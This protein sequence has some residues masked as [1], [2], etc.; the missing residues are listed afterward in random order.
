MA[1]PPSDA[2]DTVPP[3]ETERTGRGDRRLRLGVW[4][5]LVLALLLFLLVGSVPAISYRYNTFS[6]RVTRIDRSR[7]LVDIWN[8]QVSALPG[9]SIGWLPGFVFVACIVI[10]V[11]CAVAG[12]WLL[13][14]QPTG[15][16]ARRSPRGG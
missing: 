3:D 15:G 16:P 5:A 4:A 2:H 11:L 14:M 9:F 1:M 7:S 10:T 12:A 13:L 6:G 8:D